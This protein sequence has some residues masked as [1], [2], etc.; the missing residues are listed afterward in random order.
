MHIFSDIYVYV[1]VH[2]YWSGSEKNEYT[3]FAWYFEKSVG[4]LRNALQVSA[5]N[6]NG[7]VLRYTVDS[8]LFL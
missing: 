4:T 1:C 2:K 7:K 8:F 5:L 6:C 3:F